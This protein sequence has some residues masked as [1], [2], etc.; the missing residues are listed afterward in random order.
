MRRLPLV[1][2]LC[3]LS[4]GAPA[5][6]AA[7]VETLVPAPHP[8]WEVPSGLPGEREGRFPV[9]MPR[10]E[11]VTQL[12]VLSSRWIVIVTENLDE[13]FQNIDTLSHGE[14]SKAIARWDACDKTHPDWGAYK[15]RSA[16]HDQYVAQAREQAGERRLDEA[17][18]YAIT[19]NAAAYSKPLP[20]TRVTRTIVGLGGQT[21]PKAAQALR[22]IGGVYYAHYSYLELPAPLENGHTYTVALQN[23][24]RV[25]FLYDETR[26]VSRAIKVN[27]AG[28]LPDVR[29]KYAYLGAWL[30]GIGPQ[31]F[32]FAKTFRVVSVDTGDVVYQGALRLR[33]AASRVPP[34]PG[35]PPSTNDTTRPLL[36]GEDVYEM[37]LGGLAATG[38]FFIVVPGVGRSWAFRHAPDAFG[39][40][41]YTACRGLFHQRCGIALDKPYTA[42]TRPVCHTNPVYECGHVPWC[43]GAEFNRPKTY[44]IFDV[45]GGTINT[46]VDGKPLSPEARARVAHTDHVVGGWHDAADWDRGISHYAC[47]L[48]LLNAY[49]LA[50]SKFTDNQLNIPESGNGVPDVLDEAEFGLRPWKTG[51]NAAGGVPGMIETWTHP[52]IDDPNVQYAFSRRTR[53]SSLL[54]AAAAAQYAHLVKPFDKARAADYAAAA[55]KAWAFG[56]NPSNSLGSVT[57]EARRRR[58]EGEPYVITWEEKEA[59]VRPFLVHARLRLAM[60][61]GDKTFLDGIAGLTSG[62]LMPFQWPNSFRDFSPWLYFDIPHSFASSLPAAEVSRWSDFFRSQAAS[63]A[64]LNDGMPYRCSWPRYQDYWMGWGASSMNNYSRA[65]LIGN[66]LQATPA[67]REAAVQDMDAMFGCNPMGMSWTTGI[68]FTYPVD[69]QHGPSETDGILDPMPGITLY[70]VTGGAYVELR[71]TAWRSPKAGTPVTYTD[72]IKPEA[73]ARPVWRQWSCHPHLNT[74]QCEFTVAETMAST[75]FT[76]ALLLPDGWKP[77]EGLKQ[78]GPRRDEALFGYYYLP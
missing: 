72:F 35:T 50:P 25:T 64:A 65:L 68:G 43:A 2:S 31:D 78:R 8:A 61:D 56:S 9:H 66:A 13:V 71:N 34:K 55:H 73:M 45:I 44:E 22:G 48:D 42:W 53:W 37:D 10:Y 12:L 67:W 49:E 69:I 29:G 1:V 52:S 38:T 33:D 7:A 28:Y 74:A 11:G 20:P 57:I 5:Q 36:T 58:G 23:G 24:K 21:A 16:L 46:R 26:T 3:C 32:S 76:C 60:L 39:E 17:A 75:I 70:G 59:M 54:F 62:V 77:D 40:A 47:T 51:M 41:F 14:F 6:R 18:F 19:G 27:Q 15:A 4:I 63:L 30:P